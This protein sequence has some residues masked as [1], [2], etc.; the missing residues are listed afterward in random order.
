MKTESLIVIENSAPNEKRPGLQKP[1]PEC[2]AP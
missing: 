1:E 2:T